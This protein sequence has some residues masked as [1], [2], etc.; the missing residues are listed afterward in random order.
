MGKKKIGWPTQE[1]YICDDTGEIHAFTDYCWD[2]GDIVRYWKIDP[3][4]LDHSTLE[5]RPFSLGHSNEI[6]Q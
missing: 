2:N 3:D 6:D 4:Q 5:K 1:G